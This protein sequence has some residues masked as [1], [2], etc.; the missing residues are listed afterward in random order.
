M[1]MYVCMYA[2][3]TP[4]VCKVHIALP[5]QAREVPLRQWRLVAEDSVTQF[6]V[7]DIY[8]KM[9]KLAHVGSP[10]QRIRS[11]YEL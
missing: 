7:T 2:C 10:W 11:Y 3:I 5:E 9:N 8:T 6:S 4:C 1:Y